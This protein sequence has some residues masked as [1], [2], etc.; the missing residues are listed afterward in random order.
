MLLGME[1]YF[2][3]WSFRSAMA[4]KKFRSVAAAAEGI[5]VSATYLRQV[6]RGLVPAAEM[7]S[8]IAAALGVEVAELWKPADGAAA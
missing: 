4:R 5:K 8:R 7:R 1:L 3:E 6:L 2:N